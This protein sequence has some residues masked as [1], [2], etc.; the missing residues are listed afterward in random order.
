MR[1]YI[2]QR[3]QF[4]WCVLQ[5]GTLPRHRIEIKCH[6]NTVAEVHSYLC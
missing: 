2:L 3:I 1:L 6:K 4:D 5:T